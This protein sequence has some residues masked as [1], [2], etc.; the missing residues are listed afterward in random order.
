MSYP[1]RHSNPENVIANERTFF[2]TSCI[3]GRRSLLQSKRSAR[4]FIQTLHHYRAAGKF[5]LHAFVVM[6]DHFH[7]LL[8]VN[9]GMTIERA[10]QFVKGDFAFRS[11]QE[12]VFRAPIWQK[13]FSETR[14][15]DAAAFDAH[16]N[17]IHDN[18][19]RAYLA[20]IAKEYQ[21]SS[22][23][24]SIDLDPPP[25]HLVPAAT[26]GA[27]VSWRYGMPEGMP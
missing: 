13:G 9:S 8:T 24:S 20:P 15:L 1:R 16:R 27:R 11:G 10:V 22:A 18:P 14:V 21:F 7:L 6:P 3:W 2:V 26:E 23:K 25:T 19:V 17:Y 4:L 12:L 5:R